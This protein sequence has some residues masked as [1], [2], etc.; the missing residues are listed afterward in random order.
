MTIELLVWNILSSIRGYRKE[1][2]SSLRLGSSSFGTR[3][4]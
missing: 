2:P 4:V 1:R 3:K